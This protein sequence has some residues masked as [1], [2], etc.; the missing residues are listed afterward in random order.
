[1]SSFPKISALLMVVGLVAAVMLSMRLKEARIA[2]KI[3][4]KERASMRYAPYYLG[5]GKFWADIMWM[6]TINQLGKGQSKMDPVMVKYYDKQFQKI[7]NIDP[8]FGPVY[9]VGA[10]SIAYQDIDK[11][12]AL[13]DKAEKYATKQDWYWYY[14]AAHWTLQINA[15][16]AAKEA[17]SAKNDKDKKAAEGKVKGYQQHAIEL[18]QKAIDRDAPWYVESMLL[19]TTA[20]KDGNYGKP[21]AELTSMYNYYKVRL[22]KLESEQ[23][24]MNQGE[25]GGPDGGKAAPADFTP[26]YDEDSSFGRL[27]KRILEKAKSLML[28]LLKKEE[29]GDTTAVASQQKVRDIFVKMKVSYQYSIKSLK[30]Y[31]PGDLFDSVTGS[32]VTPFGI[33]LYDL[34]VN[35]RITPIK[36]AYNTRTGKK[37]AASFKDLEAMLKAENKTISSDL[38][39]HAPK[40]AGPK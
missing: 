16:N 14:Q 1:M 6:Q 18:L 31:G 24:A 36:G 4:T 34:E 5:M 12:L 20:K 3:I 11:A 33:D 15:A 21:M 26:A 29:K 2:E 28:E 17:A 25:K 38:M 32:P 30:E 13:V 9:R 35:K 27:H 22:K 19:H 37:A 40:D 10:S 23:E 7:T 8:N 39:K